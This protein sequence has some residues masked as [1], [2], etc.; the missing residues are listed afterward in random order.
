MKKQILALIYLLFAGLLFTACAPKINTA[1][2]A[3]EIGSSEIMEENQVTASATQEPSPTYTSTS[4]PTN[5]P[6]TPPTPTATATPL[7]L[8]ISSSNIEQILPLKTIQAHPMGEVLDLDISPDSK[9]T[10]T[11]S[12]DNSVRIIDLERGTIEKVFL[13]GTIGTFNVAFSPNGSQHISGHGNGDIWL[14]NNVSKELILDAMFAGP[15]EEI[16]DEKL[17]TYLILSI[18]DATLY[19]D[20]EPAPLNM[21]PELNRNMVRP[22]NSANLVGIRFGENDIPLWE[23]ALAKE[24]FPEA[25]KIFAETPLEKPVWLWFVS[26]ENKLPGDDLMLKAVF[27]SYGSN[28]SLAFSPAGESISSGS[29]MMDGKVT[30]QSL[31]DYSSVLKLDAN[32]KGRYK[33]TDTVAYSP[34]G[35]YLATGG[36]EKLVKIWNLEDGSLLQTLAGHTGDVSDIIFSQDGKKMASCG[37]NGLI[38]VWNTET[39]EYENILRHYD[40]LALEFSKDGSLLF[41]GG[42]GTILN[43]WSLETGE[44][45]KEIELSGTTKSL[46]LFSNGDYLA[47]GTVDGKITL[48]GLPEE[49]E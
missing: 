15:I 18:D 8:P 41:S 22:I 13:L 28:A 37:R 11:G 4:L 3:S 6:T 35:K 5:T 48:I 34:D 46:K 49:T 40:P 44:K 45:V 23:T 21:Y 12:T 26:Y 33:I 47:A 39:W 27:S 20:G 7:P 10:I 43:V 32:T 16:I 2:N 38:F 42:R 36:D 9:L 30:V 24:N 14:L 19:P 31:S 17:Y 29:Y 25:W 1:E